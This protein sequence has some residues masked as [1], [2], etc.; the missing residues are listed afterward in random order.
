VA[1]TGFLFVVGFGY[2]VAGQ[3]TLES[4]R[5]IEQ[6]DKLLYSSDSISEDWLMQV[7]PNCESLDNFYAPGK[8]RLVTYEEMIERILFYVRQGK[9]VCA[10]FYGHPGVCAYPSHEAIRRARLEGFGA[11][12][13]PGISAH[14][15]MVA[16]LGVDPALGC[17][18]YEATDFLIRQ[19]SVDV[20][21]AMV[22]WQIGAIGMPDETD[23]DDPNLEGLELLTSA[24]LHL[25]SAD[26]MV[27]VYQSSPYPI[28]DPVIRRVPVRELAQTP[29]T[30]NSTLYVPP[31]RE[32]L[33]DREMS[34]RIKAIE[35]RAVRTAKNMI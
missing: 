2:R 34:S 4:L 35:S 14:D 28:C 19:R 23:D 16:D 13:L 18:M 8:D 26:H 29:L 7:N 9:N 32:P 24:L 5:C 1:S 17:Q 11:R 10:A 6:A 20:S 30:T 31:L 27:T 3:V 33:I 25:Y 21:S 12:M 22:L 15:V